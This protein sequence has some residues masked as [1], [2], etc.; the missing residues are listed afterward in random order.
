MGHEWGATTG[1][2]RKCGWLDLNVVN[3][4]NKLNGFSS[5][6]ITKLDVLAGSDTLKVAT[7]DE[8]D[9]KK[10]DGSMPADVNELARC[11]PVYTELPGWTEDI[12]ACTTFES[13]PTNA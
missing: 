10:L 2:M 5:I 1:R 4:S 3:Y 13:L 7:H 6:N 12:T 11:T 8:L 9:G